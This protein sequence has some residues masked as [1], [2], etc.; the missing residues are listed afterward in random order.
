[1]G[2][3]AGENYEIQRSAAKPRAFMPQARA[4]VFNDAPPAASEE[5]LTLAAFRLALRRL[6]EWLL[7][8]EARLAHLAADS[9]ES[10]IA[11]IQADVL[12]LIAQL[13]FLEGKTAKA[14]VAAVKRM[15]ELGARAATLQSMQ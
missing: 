7:T 13:R 2:I 12:A 9:T 6:E 14:D 15:E 1:M 3:Y 4:L 5:F 8:I 10:D 11:A